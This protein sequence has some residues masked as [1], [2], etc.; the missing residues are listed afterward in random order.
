[1]IKAVAPHAAKAT[2]ETAAVSPPEAERVKN[3][4]VLLTF[5]VQYARS[6]KHCLAQC[7][8]AAGPFSR[9]TQA[10]RCA[11][12]CPFLRLENSV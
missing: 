12:P 9:K 3:D 7:L 2:C 10:L 4:K 5:L 1:M 6:Q 11:E 8:S